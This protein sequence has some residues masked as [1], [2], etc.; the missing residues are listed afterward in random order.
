MTQKLD[1]DR[2]RHDQLQSARVATEAA[3]VLTDLKEALQT[4]HDFRTFW[5][6]NVTQTKNGANPASNPMWGRIA[7]TLDKYNMSPGEGEAY[8]KYRAEYRT[9]R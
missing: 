6:D 4:L 8:Y 3:A 1:L 9:N 7:D 5:N 2:L